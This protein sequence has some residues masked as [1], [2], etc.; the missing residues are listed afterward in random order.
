MTATQ[1]QPLE[2][3]TSNF[4]LRTSLSLSEPGR[5]S[6]FE[7][8]DLETLRELDSEGDTLKSEPVVPSPHALTRPAPSS[9][10]ELPLANSS[11]SATSAS[12][13]PLCD[14]SPV[15]QSAIH[16]PQSAIV[17]ES[18]S[19]RYLER[20]NLWNRYQ[21]ITFTTKPS[22]FPPFS[23][24]KTRV[25][26]D[27]QAARHLGV[28]NATISRLAARVREHGLDGLKDAYH[29]SGRKPALT[30]TPD[31]HQRLAALYLKTNRNTEA[32][33]MQTACKFF[34]LD[35]QTREELRTVILASLERGR[36]PRFC[37]RALKQITREHFAAHR[38]PGLLATQHFSGRR[39]AFA[40]EKIERR[41]IVESDDATLNFP[42]WIP[43]PLG[44]DPCSDKY[45]VRLGRWQFLPALEAGWSQFYLG[46]TLV[47]R[48]RGSYTQEDVRA[49]IHQVLTT[50]GL[51]DSFRFERG[52][53]ESNSIL[54]LLSR[55]GIDLQTVYQSNHKPFV[56]G[57]FNSLWTYLS[58]IDGQV[59]RFRGEMEKNSLLEQK[60]QAGRADPRD[61]F[62][63][64][65]QTTAALDGAL[66]LRNSD[67][68][69]S[70]IYGEWIPE[71]RHRELG[72]ERPWQPL[73]ADLEYLF[74]PILRE[75]TVAKGTVGNTVTLADGISAPF[76]FAHDDLWRFNGQKVRVYFNPAASTNGAVPRSGISE[77]PALNNFPRPATQE[78]GEGQGEGA[79]FATI[80][81]LTRHAGFVPGDIICRAELFGD[82]PH[83]TRAAIGWADPASPPPKPSFR[84]PISAI[85]RETRALAPGGRI[86]SRTSEERDGLGSTNKIERSTPTGRAESRGCGTSRTEQIHTQQSRDRQGASP[87]ALLPDDDIE[88]ETID[89]RSTTPRSSFFPL[90]ATRER[91]EG[92][93]EGIEFETL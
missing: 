56:E 4:E 17:S 65:K 18:Q 26:S 61:H 69:H 84:G 1:A 85:R 89:L 38:K 13:R 10:V 60:C 71:V 93:G 7:D 28:S 81:A 29:N 54:D 34:A 77:R 40:R 76:Y 31:E 45:G 41:R 23:P 59:G 58:V 20:L 14:S 37:T 15:S 24:V 3:R 66:A 88:T 49:L 90:P 30:L 80:V 74:S 50:H 44:G 46:Y 55:L 82:L 51:P 11:P 43:W 36:L 47:C 64:L 78:R 39:G 92:Q 75:W 16:N 72:L 27:V 5:S 32:G 52:T 67:K 35:P 53:W 79:C 57:G 70:K 63:S 12:L 42:S 8:G 83:Y 62:P 68:R 9:F 87:S 33:S 22:P 2:L 91:G 48:P 25:L 86:T 19:L 21:E 6:L 73:P